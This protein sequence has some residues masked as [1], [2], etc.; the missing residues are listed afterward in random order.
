MLLGIDVS[1]TRNARMQGGEFLTGGYTEE[2]NG[3]WDTVGRDPTGRAV[4]TGS[5]K[6]KSPPAET[7]EGRGRQKGMALFGISGISSKEVTPPDTIRALWRMYV[8]PLETCVLEGFSSTLRTR[9]PH[10]A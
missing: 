5:R 4:R 8:T 7:A 9:T 2:G 3:G 6:R 1:C 10:H